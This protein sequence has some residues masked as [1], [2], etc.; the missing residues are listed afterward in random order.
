MTEHEAAKPKRPRDLEFEDA[1][2]QESIRG[3][4]PRTI[5]RNPST[6]QK[7]VRREMQRKTASD[8]EP[9]LDHLLTTAAADKWQGPESC[10]DG[11]CDLSS[12][13]FGPHQTLNYD[14]HLLEDLKGDRSNRRGEYHP[15]TA[16]LPLPTDVPT[17]ERKPELGDHK[18]Q[19]CDYSGAPVL[20][21]AGGYS[22]RNC[23]SYALQ[24]VKVPKTAANW[25]GEPCYKCGG[26]K[27]DKHDGAWT[28]QCNN[29]W[30]QE[31]YDYGHHSGA[32]GMPHSPEGLSPSIRDSY[33]KGHKAGQAETLK[34]IRGS[35]TAT[36]FDTQADKLNPG[37]MIRTPT[38][39]TVKVLRMR[40]HETSGGHVYMDTD[41][42]TSVVRRKSPVSIVP[43][44][45]QQQEMPGYGT[46]GGNTNQLPMDKGNVGPGGNGPATNAPG[47]SGTDC[48]V[49]GGKGTLHRQGQNYVCSK[50]GYR[51]NFGAAGPGEGYNFTD[52][53][54]QLR[55][56][57]SLSAIARRAQAVLDQTKEI[58]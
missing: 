23:G 30:Q 54:Q 44:N 32:E 15:K 28:P 41:Q 6:D 21:Q 8:V 14:D 20:S 5:R 39:Q 50:C 4:S 57:S 25:Q 19:Q 45:S 55:G 11:D 26:P 51:E 58:Q 34:T 12:H 36:Q 35:K 33:S 31:A 10:P 40:N 27:E 46:P 2:Q 13:H 24:K 53:T 9:T 48:P 42:G 1:P 17:P 3:M 52:M 18:C 38:G 49:C 29:C 56:Q 22:C 43:F 47:K 37:D 16:T 7:R